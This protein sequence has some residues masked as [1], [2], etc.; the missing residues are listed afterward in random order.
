MSKNKELLRLIESELGKFQMNLVAALELGPL[1]DENGGTEDG[2]IEV[3]VGAVLAANQDFDLET[4]A[5]DTVSVGEGSFLVCNPGDTEGLFVIDVYD[6]DS[7]PITT[8]LVI[9]QD[10]IDTLVET[11]YLEIIPAEDITYE[12]IKIEDKD[13]IDEAF[14]K[15]IHGKM[16]K[17]KLAP[18]KGFKRV[19]TKYVKISAQAMAQMR[20]NAVK[21]S[22]KANLGSAK[23]TR[24]KTMRIRK[25]KVHDSVA[26]A[27]YKVVEG[28]DVIEGD[29]DNKKTIALESG[30]VLKF[31]GSKLDISRDGKNLVSGIIVGESFL[32]ECLDGELVAEVEEVEAEVKAEEVEGEG[33]KAEEVEEEVA[34]S[35]LT[36]TNESGYVFT[37]AG[38]ATKLGNRVRTRSYLIGE[39]YSI[40]SVILDNA[41]NGKKVTL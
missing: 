13:V 4:L 7:N 18:K 35:V 24:M 31:T 14:I 28:F 11:G 29:K 17:F 32:N 10:D 5:D 41:F 34:E 40:N 39:G 38:K 22:R 25:Q 3:E 37:K 6:A 15:F 19:G 23:I 27:G 36:F 9:A 30:D 8:G 16:K 21:A 33:V 12:S 1:D 26:K 2:E 20:K